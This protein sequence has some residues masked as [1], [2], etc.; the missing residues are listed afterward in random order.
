MIIGNGLTIDLMEY[1]KPV[2]AEWGVDDYIKIFD[3]RSRPRFAISPISKKSWR[4]LKRRDGFKIM[5]RM[6]KSPGFIKLLEE[7][8]LKNYQKNYC[9]DFMI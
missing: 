6:G 7:K 3:N 8:L 2:L 4:H 1:V 5:K 9:N